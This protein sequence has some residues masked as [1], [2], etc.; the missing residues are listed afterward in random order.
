MNTVNDTD[1]R[2]SGAPAI[3][4]VSSRN[5]YTY[6]SKKSKDGQKRVYSVYINVLCSEA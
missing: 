1:D 6:F 3:P 4:G 2:R 5:S